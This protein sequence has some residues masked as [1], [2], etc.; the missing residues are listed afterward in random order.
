[1]LSANTTYWV[2]A[3]SSV[4]NGYS[5]R[6][7]NVMGSYRFNGGGTGGPWTSSTFYL[8]TMQV[9][10]DAGEAPELDGSSALLPAFL[11]VGLLLGGRRKR[12]A[13]G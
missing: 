2:V 9:L 8:P 5:W 1:M 3:S 7:S 13:Q 6:M 11:A 10:A 4:L 12:A